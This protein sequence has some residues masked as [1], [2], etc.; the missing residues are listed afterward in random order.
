LDKRKGLIIY[1]KFA[2]VWIMVPDITSC[3]ED[4]YKMLNVYECPEGK[5]MKRQQ[6][7]DSTY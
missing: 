1:D 4:L 6:K 7:N 3:I 5:K 2:N